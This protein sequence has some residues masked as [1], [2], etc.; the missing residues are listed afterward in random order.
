MCSIFFIKCLVQICSFFLL[1]PICSVNIWEMVVTIFIREPNSRRACITICNPPYFLPKSEHILMVEARI[2][3]AWANICGRRAAR[4]LVSYP[5]P[6]SSFFFT[7][8]CFVNHPG[9]S[10]LA[11]IWRTNFLL[12]ISG[13]IGTIIDGWGD[14]LNDGGETGNDWL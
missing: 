12:F 13:A 9:R 4:K 1:S 10:W 3:G 14:D 8:L 7:S 5:K 11:L 6:W 2:I